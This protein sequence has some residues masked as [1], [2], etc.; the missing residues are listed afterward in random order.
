MEKIIQKIKECTEKCKWCPLAIT[1]AGVVLLLLG[2]FLNAAAIKA[3]WLLI[4]ILTIA[5]GGFCLYVT[6]K[7]LFHSKK[8]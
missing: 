4:A 6:H 7:S 3:L 2:F 8:E 5:A 1:I